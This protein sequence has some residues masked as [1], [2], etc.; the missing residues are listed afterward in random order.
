MPVVVLEN[1]MKKDANGKHLRHTVV[2]EEN[3]IFGEGPNRVVKLKNTY[4]KEPTIELKLDGTPNSEGWALARS[5]PKDTQSAAGAPECMY[6]E[7]A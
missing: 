2:L 6:I 4:K 1:L 7:I 3:K 5:A